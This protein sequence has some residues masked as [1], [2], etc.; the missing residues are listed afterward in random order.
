MASFST[1]SPQKDQI[2]SLIVRH[3]SAS[4]WRVTRFSPYWPR[5]PLNTAI[6]GQSL[7][8]SIKNPLYQGPSPSEQSEPQQL[9]EKV[10]RLVLS[11]SLKDNGPRTPTEEELP[12]LMR[13]FPTL[14]SV[15][16]EHPFLVVIVEDLPNQPWPTI[17]ADLPLWLTTPAKGRPP[18]DCGLRARAA[19]KFHVKGEIKYYET[20]NEATVW[21]ILVLVNERGAGVDRIRWDGCTFHAF[22]NQPPGE[23]W[24][25][26]LPSRVNGFSISYTWTKSTMAEHALRLKDPTAS[27]TDDTQYERDQLRPGIMLAGFH[28]NMKEGLGTTSGVCVESPTSGKKFITVAAH[29]FTASVGDSVYHPRISHSN[30]VPDARYLIG[31]I[32]RKFGDTDIALAELVPGIKYSRVT[33][34]GPQPGLPEARPFRNF[35][36]PRTLK[37]GDPVFMNTPVNGPCEGVHFTTDWLFGFEAS[38]D[39]PQESKVHCEISHFSYWGNGSDIFFEGCCG[40][41]IWDEN[42]DVLGQFRFQERDGLKRAF[43]P[44]FKVLMEQ[45]YQLSE[46]GGTGLGEGDMAR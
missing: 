41:V 6:S 39:A 4:P 43:A 35:R 20:P 21:E 38:D 15:G 5:N 9:Q 10:I 26:R 28:N 34:S 42:F 45:G 16:Y 22:G 30:G 11:F 46:I 14:R 18:V 31:T 33:F 2:Q 36:D 8:K 12:E 25:D 13:H 40:G 19:Q 29:G 27:S 3:K 32:D 44:T 17:V 1:P 7:E 24:Q 23:G 37:Y